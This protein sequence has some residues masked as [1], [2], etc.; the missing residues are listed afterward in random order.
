MSGFGEC[1]RWPTHRPISKPCPE[2]VPLVARPVLSRQDVPPAPY[3]SS[4]LLVRLRRRYERRGVLS[5]ASSVGFCGVGL[6]ED[7]LVRDDHRDFDAVLV[8]PEDVDIG[9]SNHGVLMYV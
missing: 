2:Y 1:Q 6:G 8:D 5:R 3:A 7:P 4:L 9:A